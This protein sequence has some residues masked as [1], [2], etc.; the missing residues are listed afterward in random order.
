VLDTQ[1]YRSNGLAL[2]YWPMGMGKPVRDAMTSVAERGGRKVPAS[3]CA[4]KNWGR[5]VGCTATSGFGFQVTVS[6]TSART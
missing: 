5:A 1:F 4:T 2:P 3:G 6:G